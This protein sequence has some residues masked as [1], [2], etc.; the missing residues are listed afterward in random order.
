[1]P[2]ECGDAISIQ[3]GIMNIMLVCVTIFLVVIGF[4]GYAGIKGHAKDIAQKTAK[5][6]A[7]S[8]IR[9]LKRQEEA[10]KRQ[11]TKTTPSQEVLVKD[12]Q[13]KPEEL[14]L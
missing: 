9:E 2:R 13:I 8:Y 4:L 3:F 6:T 5:D 11:D 10:K 12:D 14:N 7:D 1:M